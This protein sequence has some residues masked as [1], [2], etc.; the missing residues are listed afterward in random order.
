LSSAESSSS[1]CRRIAFIFWS[2]IL[3]AL[4]HR[5]AAALAVAHRHEPGHR[6]LAFPKGQR[7]SSDTEAH[8][9]GIRH[10]LSGR[11]QILQR[12]GREESAEFVIASLLLEV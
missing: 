10:E 5:L 9:R 3:T 2:L 12:L 6:R 8:W 1:F 11:M 4:N 7:F